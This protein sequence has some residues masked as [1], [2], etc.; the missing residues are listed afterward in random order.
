MKNGV[1][2]FEDQKTKINGAGFTLIELVITIVLI[3]I[4]AI[5]AAPKLS[6][7]TDFEDDAEATSFIS[8]VRYVQHK[9]MA[10]GGGYR[11]DFNST[12][13]VYRVFDH[14]GAAENF[15]DLSS[16]TVTVN[17]LTSSVGSVYFNY[18]GQPT[19][20][21]GTLLTTNVNVSVS[22]KTFVITPYAGGVYVQ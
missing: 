19:D 13:N 17:S 14:T 18:L 5:Y 9:S 6:S 20:N 11:I 22:G 1:Q 4:I 10:T 7:I 16:N 12:G 3:G 2:L 8:R 21:S 15:P